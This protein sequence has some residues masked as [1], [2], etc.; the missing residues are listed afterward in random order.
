[1]IKLVI[2]I[3]ALAASVSLQSVAPSTTP[4]PTPVPTTAPTTVPTPVTTAASVVPTTNVEVP[5]TFLVGQS[6]DLDAL[7]EINP[8]NLLT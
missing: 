6:S 7:A 5:D 3:S 1:M 4:A 8:T 2:L